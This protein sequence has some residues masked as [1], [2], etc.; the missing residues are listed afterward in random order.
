MDYGR[1]YERNYSDDSEHLN[2]REHD[3]TQVSKMSQEEENKKSGEKQNENFFYKK[4]GFPVYDYF[5]GDK[6]VFQR[7]MN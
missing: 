2:V 3:F 4:M 6:Q 7:R 1:D 5:E